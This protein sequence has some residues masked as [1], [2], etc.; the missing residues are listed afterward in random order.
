MI[1]INISTNYG[2]IVAELDSEG[3]PKTVANFLDYIHSGHYDDTIFHRVIKDFMIQGGGFAPGMNQKP[4][5]QTVTNEARNGLK[6]VH[7]SLAMARTSAPHSASA[8]FFINTKD[9][10]FLDYPGQDGWGYCVFGKVVEGQKVV[11]A[12]QAVDVH[13]TGGHAD[14]P[15]VDVVI[16]SIK[17]I[18]PAGDVDGKD[19]AKEPANAVQYV[20]GVIEKT[21]QLM[22]ELAAMDFS[23][24]H[25]SNDT[26][27]N[28]K[29]TIESFDRAMTSTAGDLARVKAIVNVGQALDEREETAEPAG[30][31]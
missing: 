30:E 6:N 10:N 18:N 9:N 28:V 24:E 22:S 3:A 7:Y 31:R 2:D 13:R 11:D 14:V 5:T 26:R 4:A 20:T 17:V 27:D 8:Q 21:K 1:K 12:I 29:R 19:E 15:M 25:W 23:G 16:N